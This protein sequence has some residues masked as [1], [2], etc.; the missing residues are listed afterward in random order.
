LEDNAGIIFP[1]MVIKDVYH[2]GV[3]RSYRVLT[4]NGSSKAVVKWDYS[5]SVK[6]RTKDEIMYENLQ[7]RTLP[8]LEIE[9]IKGIDQA[10]QKLNAFLR[11]FNRKFKITWAQRSCAVLLH[12]SHGTGKTF[13]MDKVASTGWGKVYRIESDAKPSVIREEFVKA[14]LN[15]PSIIII[16]ELDDMVRASNVAKVL[17]QEL[18]NLI[19]DHPADSLP[20]V[21][22]MAASLDISS[23]PMPLRDEGRFETAVTLPLPD[24]TARRAILKHMAPPLDPKN[25]DET[26]ERLGDRTHAYTAKDLKSLL[27]QACYFAEERSG[28]FGGMLDL[29]TLLKKLLEVGLYHYLVSLCVVQFSGII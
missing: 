27:R 8:K 3:K 21:L 2:E 25:R 14:R 28:E 1:G 20:K 4:V 16:D 26:L 24:S 18:D 5:S 12:G 23:I 13:I 11:N 22:V 6:I 7:I 17:G 15:Q 10:L 19:S 9:D 29:G